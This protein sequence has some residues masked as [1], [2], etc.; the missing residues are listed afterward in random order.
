M[1]LLLIEDDLDHCELYRQQIA[2]TGHHCILCVAHGVKD[3]LRCVRRELPDA[4]LL[5]LELR[6]SDGSGLLFL[7]TLQMEKDAAPYIIVITNNRSDKTFALAR[8][9]GA[10]FIIPKFKPDYSPQ[11]VIDFAYQYYLLYSK[12]KSVI[13]FPPP[14]ETEIDRLLETLGV[15]HDMTGRTYLIEAVR[16][17]AEQ[18]IAEVQLS[19]A[20]YPII[21]RK[22]KKSDASIDKAIGNAIRKAWRTTDLHALGQAYTTGISMDKGVPTNKELIWYLADQLAQGEPDMIAHARPRLSVR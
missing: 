17:V 11:Y 8:Q 10:D 1:K 12:E 7:Q 5:D 6:G 19:K 2:V 4:I 9:S 18:G 14:V 22:Y 21:A 3:A 15:T 16:I 13:D 20:V